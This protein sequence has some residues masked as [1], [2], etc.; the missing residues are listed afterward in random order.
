MRSA[1]H[2]LLTAA[3]LPAALSLAACSDSP[4]PYGDR[5]TPPPSATDAPGRAPANAAPAPTTPPGVP[6][7]RTE[8]KK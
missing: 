8:T 6:Q 7:D 4:R 3:L 1:R 2:W 5:T